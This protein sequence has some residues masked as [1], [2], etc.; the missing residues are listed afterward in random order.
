MSTVFGSTPQ[1]TTGASISSP[2]ARATPATRPPRT[3]SVETSAPVRTSAPAAAAA[4]SSALAS[5]AGPPL[6]NVVCPAAPPSFP[7]ESARSTRAVPADHGPMAV[8]SDPRA[9]RGPRTA[10]D[11]NHSPTK[12][13]A[14]IGTARVS[15]RAARALRRR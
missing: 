15:S 13:A 10:S 11:V 9:A 14:A 3:S 7:A 5:A 4:A 8:K 6:A 1:A 12:S 2:E